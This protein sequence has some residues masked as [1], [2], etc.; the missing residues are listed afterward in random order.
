MRFLM[1][2]GVDGIGNYPCSND[3]RIFDE[4]SMG[5]RRRSTNIKK[6]NGGHVCNIDWRSAIISRPRRGRH[7]GRER[8]QL[9]ICCGGFS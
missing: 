2:P 1:T 9:Q 3:A 7:R 5:S 8:L 6:P 4:A